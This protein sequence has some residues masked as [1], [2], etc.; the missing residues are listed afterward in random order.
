MKKGP[1]GG[2]RS[3]Y[4]MIKDDPDYFLLRERERE[5]QRERERERCK[6]KDITAVTSAKRGF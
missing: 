1:G 5:R 3:F 2:G 4:F 6:W